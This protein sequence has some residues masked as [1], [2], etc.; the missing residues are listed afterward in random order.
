MSSIIDPYLIYALFERV[1]VRFFLHTC[2]IQI[3][4]PAK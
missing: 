2:Y 4:S 3:E 1:L